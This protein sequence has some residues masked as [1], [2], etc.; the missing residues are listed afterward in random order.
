MSP[1]Y[2]VAGVPI[3]WSPKVNRAH[4]LILWK[5]MPVRHGVDQAE[6]EDGDDEQR[7]GGESGALRHCLADHRRRRSRQDVAGRILGHWRPVIAS[8]VPPRRSRRLL[9]DQRAAAAST[10]TSQSCSTS[11]APIASTPMSQP[12]ELPGILP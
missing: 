11:P 7:A 8:S 1:H 12:C 9:P 6:R 5:Q 3:G 2:R 4:E 10:C